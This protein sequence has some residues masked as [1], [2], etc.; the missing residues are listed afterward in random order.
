MRSSRTRST[1]SPSAAAT[2][3]S[4]TP[5][6]RRSTS[7]SRSCGAVGPAV[8][9]AAG[10]SARALRE[11]TDEFVPGVLVGVLA[12]QLTGPSRRTYAPSAA[13]A[14]PARPCSHRGS[15]VSSV[16]ACSSRPPAPATN[17]SNSRARRRLLVRAA[18][19]T[20]RLRP[21]VHRTAGR[22][23]NQEVGEPGGRRVDGVHRVLKRVSSVQKTSRS[24]SVHSSVTS[25][26]QLAPRGTHLLQPRQAA[27]RQLEH[28]GAAVLGVRGALDQTRCR[29]A[30]RPAG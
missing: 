6:Y 16:A 18:L 4:A 3:S 13:S 15:P 14:A 21:P 22:W 27:R 10:G 1:G 12:A 26:H 5:S 28:H 29:P 7:I 17:A 8:R 11:V 24:S 19:P 23:S 25:C 20:L 2:C 30:A 9:R